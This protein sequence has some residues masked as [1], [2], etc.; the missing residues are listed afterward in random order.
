[1]PGKSCR[2]C[3]NRAFVGCRERS[4]RWCKAYQ[5]D[6]FAL[7]KGEARWTFKQKGKRHGKV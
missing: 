7:A 4:A 5:R 3:V 2:W 6:K 1:M